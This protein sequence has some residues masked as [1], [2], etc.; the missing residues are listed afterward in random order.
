MT[1]AIGLSI[2]LLIAV[3]SGCTE[4]RGRDAPYRVAGRTMGTNFS[5]QV[6][7]PVSDTDLENDVLSRLRVLNEHLSTYLE[8]S[9]LSRINASRSLDWL[10]ISALLCDVLSD[11]Q[12]LSARTDGAF[13]VTLGQL[14]N[15]WGFGPTPS[16]SQPP[17]ADDIATSLASGGHQ[18]LEVDCSKPALRKRNAALSI[19]LSAY[20]KGYAA[21]DIEALLRARGIENFL[22]EIGG[23]LRV[24]GHNA[25]AERWGI[26]VERPAPTGRAV[27]T[28]LRVSSPAGVATSGDYRNYFE[29]DGERYSHT[30]DP[31]TGRPVSHNAAS[32]TVIAGSAAEADG[33][34]TALLVLGPERGLEFA[35][36][37]GIAA[38]FLLRDG[39]E[40][41]EAYSSHL[42]RNAAL[43]R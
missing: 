12:S 27:Q 31:E 18:Q 10:P 22:V 14:V 4:D 34:A 13:D 6:V 20:A 30:I 8:N 32:V 25:N 15:L 41:S 33:L 3:T 24:S 23:E 2:A 39:D 43:G 42:E 19:D 37:R 35:E 40:L 29:H 21:D 26:A 28:V 11:A 9:E 7:D 1:R 36:Q 16:I 5:I 17:S 38:Y